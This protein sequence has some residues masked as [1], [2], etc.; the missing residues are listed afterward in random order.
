MTHSLVEQLSKRAGNARTRV[1]TALDS[2]HG[3]LTTALDSAQQG[4]TTAQQGLTSARKQATTAVTG[5]ADRARDGAGSIRDGVQDG[6]SSIRDSIQNSADSI[7]KSYV[8]S[9]QEAKSAQ[10]AFAGLAP[11]I[12]TILPSEGS[13][14][15]VDVEFEIPVGKG[16]GFV[17]MHVTG[18]IARG[19][20]VAGSGSALSGSAVQLGLYVAITGGAE[21]HIAKA[22]VEAGAYLS[23]QGKTAAGALDI[24]SWTL[25]RN[26]LAE[27]NLIPR[28][29][30]DAMYGKKDATAQD[31]DDETRDR[32][33]KKGGR[34]FD[35]TNSGTV[36]LSVGAS[37]DIGTGPVTG[38]VGAKVKA[39][40]VYD[41]ASLERREGAKSTTQKL[42][43]RAAESGLPGLSHV[44]EALAETD[45]GAQASLGDRALT[46]VGSAAVDATGIGSTSV[47]VTAVLRQVKD[48]RPGQ[49]SSQWSLTSLMVDA[50]AKSPALDALASLTSGAASMVSVVKGLVNASKKATDHVK[51]RVEKDKGTKA[52][53]ALESI[54]N[55]SDGLN[56]AFTAASGIQIP[57]TLPG[58]TSTGA[59]HFAGGMQAKKLN[60]YVGFEKVTSFKVNAKVLSA[61]YEKAERIGSIEYDGAAWSV[62][63]GDLEQEILRGKK[64]SSTPHGTGTAHSGGLT[65]VHGLATGSAHGT[66]TGSAHG[67]TTGS[68]HGSTTGS[69]H[70]GS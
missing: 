7:H 58:V 2:A 14:C 29:L 28:E 17:G 59:I 67:T 33:F 1:G 50:T 27:S 38:S 22:K 8:K 55:F 60:L 53:K 15:T 46:F 68:A 63:F 43:G 6:A 62:H 45:R 34:D 54:N 41:A 49:E 66:T 16:V 9:R 64:D 26:L 61:G 47:V 35:P 44:G 10:S 42:V 18:T 39:G 48:K 3:G 69:A 65:P 25:Y 37:A 23:T 11:V 5:L 51:S 57:T 32:Y 70:G 12:D 52:G 20:Y 56:T 24:A 4:L 31:W 30:V 21:L 36:G 13:M 40:R 19:T